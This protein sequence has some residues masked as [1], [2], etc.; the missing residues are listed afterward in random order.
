MAWARF[1]TQDQWSSTKQTE[2]PV[3]QTRTSRCPL[4][5]HSH[6]PALLPCRPGVLK[7]GQT[8]TIEPMLVDGSI[9][10]RAWKDG[11]TIVT[12][13]GSLTAQF[14]HT[15]LVT[16]DG[17]EILTPYGDNPAFP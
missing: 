10:E 4:P 17:V 5:L 16:D 9:A 11:W 15:L 7:K 14:E 2:T 13:D 12:A 8:F 1:F 3:Y 6:Q